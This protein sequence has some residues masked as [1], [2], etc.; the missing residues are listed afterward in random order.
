[1]IFLRQCPNKY[2]YTYNHWLSDS[3]RHHHNHAI[4]I[5]LYIYWNSGNMSICHSTVSAVSPSILLILSLNLYGH[6]HHYYRCLVSSNR[7]NDLIHSKVQSYVHNLHT[8]LILILLASHGVFFKMETR[9][10]VCIF[11]STSSLLW[12]ILT[13]RE[14]IRRYSILAHWENHDSS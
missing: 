8:S 7:N 5:H 1:M 4:S 9:K 14:D 13:R 12:S 6:H 3:V 10:V 11:L 2:M